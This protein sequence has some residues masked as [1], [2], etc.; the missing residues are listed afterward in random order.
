MKGELTITGGNFYKN[1]GSEK[2]GVV[3]AS[4][5]GFMNISGG[6]FEGNEA[7]NGGAVYVGEDAALSVEEGV[8]TEN[9]ARNGGGVFWTEDGGD[10]E[11][12]IFPRRCFRGLF[13]SVHLCGRRG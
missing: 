1:T 2:G 9:V 4:E 11:V 8:F 7:F 6:N 10:I 12:N 5:E 13:W 3:Y